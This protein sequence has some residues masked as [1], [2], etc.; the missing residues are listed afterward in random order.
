M[1]KEP[2][3]LQERPDGMEGYWVA[4]PARMAPR[5]GDGVLDRDMI[6][7]R[8]YGVFTIKRGK[9]RAIFEDIS[10]TW[11]GVYPRLAA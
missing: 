5:K 9:Y 11:I 4:Q 1:G 7:A 8:L 3:V 10:S 2:I 6:P